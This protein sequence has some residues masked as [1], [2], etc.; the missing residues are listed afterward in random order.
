MENYWNLFLEEQKNSIK[1]LKEIY[2]KEHVEEGHTISYICKKYNLPFNYVKSQLIDLNLPIIRR[3]YVS[4][5]EL[6][7]KQF[8]ES[9]YDGKIISHDRKLLGGQKEI[10]LYIPEFNLGIEYHGSF[11]HSNIEESKHQ[12]KY[13][14]AKKANIELIQLFDWELEE[15][16]DIVFS[17][18]KSRFG[19]Y[20][21]KINARDCLVKEISLKEYKLFCEENHMQG[22]APS[23]IKLGLFHKDELVS[24][25]SFS[26]PR[27]KSN[28]DYEM[29]RFCNKK[30]SSIRG[31]ASKLFSYFTKN[32]NFSSIISFSDNRLFNGKLYE[33][34]GFNYSHDSS[35]N[36][37]YIKGQDKLS[38]ISAQKHKLKNLLKEGFNPELSEKENML[39]N[40][41]RIIFDAGNKVFVYYK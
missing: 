23:R 32:F 29:I 39:S 28:H 24:I 31:G 6:I 36:Y 7:I 10:D 13:L 38:R 19:F 18:I 14:L 30:Y 26:R 27:S 41:Y 1:S 25:M 9:F 22:Y 12:N 8:I 15:K 17:L 16:E 40:G 33:K 4:N 2:D 3:Y 21:H 11:W 37:W 35:P 5:G 20:D 34:L